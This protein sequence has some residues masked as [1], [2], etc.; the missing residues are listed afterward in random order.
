MIPNQI[1]KIKQAHSSVKSAPVCKFINN[2]IEFLVHPRLMIQ[3]VLNRVC[4]TTQINTEDAERKDLKR[5]KCIENLAFMNSFHDLYY[6]YSSENELKSLR[7][8]YIFHSINTVLRQNELMF[9]NDLKGKFD[10]IFSD[11]TP[12]FRKRRKRR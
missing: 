12:K 4:L 8:C 10:P 7:S 11:L 9:A 6:E 5:S 3:S 1:W 2:S